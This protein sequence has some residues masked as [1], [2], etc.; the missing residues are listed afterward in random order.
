MN[1]LTVVFKQ[2]IKS[3]ENLLTDNFVERI[4]LV[5]NKPEFYIL[6][7]F[8]Q[9]CYIS[10]LLSVVSIN[11]NKLTKCP[12]TPRVIISLSSISRDAGRDF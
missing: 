6:F 7:V 3:K 1:L 11:L 12:G 9:L 2:N 8:Q 10:Y 4:D 5:K